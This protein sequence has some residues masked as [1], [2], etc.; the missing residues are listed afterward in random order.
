MYKI[1]VPTGAREVIEKLQAAGH[2]AYVV[3]G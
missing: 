2:E 3:G 1:D